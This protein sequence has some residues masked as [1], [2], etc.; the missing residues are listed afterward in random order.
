[1]EHLIEELIKFN[2]KDYY[3]PKV[4]EAEGADFM[5]RFGQISKLANDIADMASERGYILYEDAKLFDEK[6]MKCIQE[7]GELLDRLENYR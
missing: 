5:E 3:K 7:L 1:M 2:N 6:Q 4:V